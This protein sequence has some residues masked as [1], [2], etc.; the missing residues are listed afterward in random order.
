MVLFHP[1]IPYLI[2]LSLQIDTIAQE[3]DSYDMAMPLSDVPRGGGHVGW[4]KTHK[5]DLFL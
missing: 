2:S 3:N 1:F 5:V 4:N